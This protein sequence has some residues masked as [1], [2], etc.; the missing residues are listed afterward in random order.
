[1]KQC[2]QM[3]VASRCDRTSRGCEFG[4]QFGFSETVDQESESIQLAPR[5]Q[6]I[7]PGVCRMADGG[8]QVPHGGIPLALMF[9]SQ[10]ENDLE[11]RAVGG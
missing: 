9:G 10:P 2:R 1:M 3:W 11:T 8:M 6:S 5:I 7:V 4:D